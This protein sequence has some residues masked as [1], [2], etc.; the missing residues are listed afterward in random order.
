MEILIGD[1][2][3]STWSMR[4]WLVLKRS[5]APFS[6]TLVRLRTPQ[7]ND[8]AR[9]AGSPSGLVPV[10][11]DG[12]VTVW[13]SIAIC[14]YLAEKLPDARLWPADPGARSAARSAVAE[15]HA[16]FHSLRGECPMDLR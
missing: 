1:K 13:D 3:W 9:A 12:D 15:M 2:A 7:T 6:E 5:G 8:N 14:E 4:P 16:G 10:L 11:K